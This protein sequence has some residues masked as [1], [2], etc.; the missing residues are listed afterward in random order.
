MMKVDS[1]RT[2]IEFTKNVLSPEDRIATRFAGILEEL[3]VG[4]VIVAGYI[5]I[6]FGRA[7]RSD[8]VDFLVEHI[9]LEKFFELC[10][11]LRVGGFEGLQTDISRSTEV[12]S[13][14]HRYLSQG[15]SV[16]FALQGTYIPNVELK[17]TRNYLHLYSLRNAWTVV[18]NNS[19]TLRIA[20]LELQIPYKLYLG[21][22][23]DIDDAVYLYTLFQNRLNIELMHK[24]C[25][26]LGVD[27]E[28]LWR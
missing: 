5:A 15:Y 8:D 17:L 26:E 10:E 4:Y 22:D 23:K 12:E 19:Y 7:R 11:K 3:G 1:G 13:L 28:V 9:T 20:P 27:C 21:G 24:W 14:Y 16:R 18:L 2:V 6:L 25:E